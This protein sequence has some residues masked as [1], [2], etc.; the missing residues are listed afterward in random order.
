[1]ELKGWLARDKDGSLRLFDDVPER[2]YEMFYAYFGLFYFK[3]PK[4]SFPE[5]T[6]ENS[7]VEVTIK[8]EKLIEL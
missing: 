6:W 8:I 3:P 5:V 1:M 2:D 7:P 4:D